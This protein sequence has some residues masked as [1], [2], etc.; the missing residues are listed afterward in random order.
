MVY[1]N[2]GTGGRF[3]LLHRVNVVAGDNHQTALNQSGWCYM[4]VQGEVER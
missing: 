4:L 2:L 3:L 1:E